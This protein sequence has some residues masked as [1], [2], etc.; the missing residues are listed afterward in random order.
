MGERSHL[1]GWNGLA[2]RQKIRGAL[3]IAAAFATSF[4]CCIGSALAQ[5]APA[6]APPLS[7]VEEES[8]SAQSQ[9]TQ[10]QEVQFSG[11][12]GKPLPPEVQ[13]VLREQFKRIPPE[14]LSDDGDIVVRSKKTS[15]SIGFDAVLE[16]AF[17]PI[18][19]GAYGAST[20][21]ELIAALG[22]QIT[23]PRSQGDAPPLLL[24]NGRRL[25]NPRDIAAIPAEAIEKLE[26][27]PEDAAT[28]FGLPADR[29]VLNIITLDE[30]TGVFASG[31]G[32]LTTEGGGA[33]AQGAVDLFKING[34]TR[35]GFG[36]SY[37]V[38]RELTEAQ[39]SIVQ[40]SGS[41]ALARFRA[42][43]PEIE[44]YSVNGS[45]ARPI[46]KE[47]SASVT[48]RFRGER[49]RGQIGASGASVL[50]NI[51]DSNDWELGAN[52]AGEFGDLRLLFDITYAKRS[53]FSG[54]SV[55]GSGSSFDFTDADN[56]DFL[57]RLDAAGTL[58][59]LPAGP[60]K[61]SVILEG[62]V[63]ELDSFTFQDNLQIGARRIRDNTGV[64]ANLSIPILS[65]V[66]PAGRLSTSY[67]LSFA[68]L[69]DVDDT[70]RL[71]AR[72]DWA[73]SR[74]LRFSFAFVDEQR[75]PSLEQLGQPTL[76]TPNV[77]TLD[78]V[79]GETVDLTFV[80]GGNPDL[81]NESER[82]FQAQFA[83]KPFK[84]LNFSLNA[85]FLASRVND[86][87]APFPLLTTATTNAFE[88]RFTRDANAQLTEIDVRPI[89][90][91]KSV[92]NQIFWGLSFS[93]SLGP[94]S[95]DGEEAEQ[96][97]KSVEEAAA[98]NPDDFVFAVPANSA[99]ARQAQNISSRIF[100]N[101]YHTWFTRDEITLAPN[102]SPLNLRRGDAVDLFGG[103]RQHR[104]EF[105]AGAYKSGLGGRVDLRWDSPTSL[106]GSAIT[107]GESLRF[108]S[109]A[110]LNVN[111]FAN[112]QEVFDKENKSFLLKK[113]RLTL[114]V[115][116]VFNQ[117][118]V[119]RTDAGLTPIRFQQ[120]YLDPLGRTLSLSFR[121]GF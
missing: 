59:S 98:A 65:P 76:R 72:V 38:S 14:Q 48:G 36:G 17:T 81:L 82:N 64:S 112:L 1:P 18:E 94:L 19:I 89:N 110:T 83:L 24:L 63:S 22:A 80:T 46:G 27:F 40:P 55:A 71:N 53:N 75:P 34:D 108:N 26:V 69:S 109:L 11:P 77:R 90:F 84:R 31:T 92:R 74:A 33:T 111:V 5:A 116:N 9:E 121:K 28:Y 87:L 73:P 13:A 37:F 61:G 35:V 88:G 79:T 120:A 66:S 70:R 107:G 42:L 39:R 102:T 113:S 106:T 3:Q 21:E 100:A 58:V 45:F 105:V 12:D 78:F 97:F 54:I 20:V 99:L 7:Q 44:R 119:V 86:P 101:V 25:P 16:R 60:L 51:R 93:R 117:R 32:A 115:N 91:S 95:D 43:L 57:V 104:I 52:L 30:F 50:E 103:R 62:G 85:T 15:K 4:S 2:A 23:G 67:G 68:S 10:E 49:S 118:P 6:T 56:R 8:E 47:I 114:D 96:N 41:E 29:K